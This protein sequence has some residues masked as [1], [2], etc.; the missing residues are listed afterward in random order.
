MLKEGAAVAATM[1]RAAAPPACTALACF[2]S[3][4]GEVEAQTALPG[5]PCGLTEFPSVWTDEEEWAWKE[6]CEGR[7]ADFTKYLNDGFDP[8][9]PE[10]REKWWDN[11]RILSAGFLETV[12]LHEPF[13]SAVP[14]QGVRING[15]VF[16]HD[17]D[18]SYA[19]I[20][21]YLSITDSAFESPVRFDHATAS[22]VI[23]LD[24]SKFEQ[25]FDMNGA[26]IRGSLVLQQAEFRSASMIGA[27]IDGQVNMKG[28]RFAG[29]LD[30]AAVSIGESL[31]MVAVTIGEGRQVEG[32]DF[33]ALRL[34]GADIA[35]QVAMTNS[36]FRGKLE[37]DF[38]RHRRE[39]P[40]K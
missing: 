38:H 1:M 6:I 24:G 25:A 29:S 39:P 33:L 20:R 14:F 36:K 9:D 19:E 17:I 15:A 8:K 22:S 11:H 12:L 2:L 18:L 40:H 31:Q 32:S 13:R 34:R 37:M 10:H 5:Q 23:A 30:M 16:M 28:S 7:I 4:A 27:N 21:R 3:F 35:G 26:S